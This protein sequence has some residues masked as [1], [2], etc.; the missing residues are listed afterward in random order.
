MND[1][2]RCYTQPKQLRKES[3][4]WLPTENRRKWLL[5]MYISS[6]FYNVNIISTTKVSWTTHFFNRAT[7][8]NQQS[9]SKRLGHLFTLRHLIIPSPLSPPP[10]CT[11][12]WPKTFEGFL[13]ATAWV[14]YNCDDHHLF[15]FP[16]RSSH[17]YD[18]HT[19]I[20]SSSFYDLLPVGL[21]AQLVDRFTGMAEVKGSNSV[22]AWIFFRLSF[23][24]CVGCVW[25]RW[26]SF[27]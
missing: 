3:Q 22:Q 9:W 23:R 24:N 19:F 10:D 7:L 27:I 25:L 18:F 1:D 26:S 13:F 15:N 14:A 12:Y 5:V 8:H 6:G 2:H 20:T 17:I 11:G 21:L 4:L 16:L